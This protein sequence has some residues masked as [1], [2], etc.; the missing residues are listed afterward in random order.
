MKLF[1]MVICLLMV[2]V[3]GW[4]DAPNAISS[5]VGIRAIKPRRAVFMAAVFNV[6][7]TALSTALGGK[8][9]KTVINLSSFHNIPKGEQELGLCTAMLGVIIFG[10]IAAL[11]GLPTSES[12]A[13]LAGISGSALALGGGINTQEWRGVIFGLIASLL[14]PLTISVALVKLISSVC[15]T[16]HRRKLDK[17]FKGS[18]VVGAALASFLHGAQDGQKFIGVLCIWHMGDDP[19][20]S[21]LWLSVTVGAVMGIGTAVGGYKIIKNVG[22]SM[23]KLQPFQG[24]S[25]EASGVMSL[26]ILTV[27][28]I[29]VSTTHVKTTALLGAGW[30]L[31]RK[32]VNFGVVKDMLLA[33]ALTFPFCGLISYLIS[34]F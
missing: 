1:F 13:L 33:W 23:V 7:G 4:T 16:L 24:F 30:A 29:P 14:A 21:L 5:A 19:N 20:G 34:R 28:G 27:L 2:F 31:G 32:Q 17:F 3:N 15:K 8:V 12:H 25:A 11:F 18:G 22:L 6:L 26:Y 9:A 10:S